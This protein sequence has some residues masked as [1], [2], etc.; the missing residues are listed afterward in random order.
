M[1]DDLITRTCELGRV[2]MPHPTWETHPWGHESS[3]HLIGLRVMN[4]PNLK[5]SRF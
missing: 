1:P 3:D 2:R 5:G 4:E